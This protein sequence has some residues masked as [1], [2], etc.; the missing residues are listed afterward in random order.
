MTGDSAPRD[1]ATTKIR[2]CLFDMD[3]LLI[4]SEE[5]YTRVTNQILKEHGKG[6]LPWDVKIHLQGRPGPE[7]SR[8]F[9]D[10]AQLPYTPEEYYKLTSEKQ[11]HLWK[12]TKFMPGALEL[13]QYLDKHNVPFALATSSH[14]DNYVL[15]T[16]H[17][18]DGFDLFGKHI[19]V[20]DDER[21]P[22]GRG[23]PHPDIWQVALAS[24]NDDRPADD[25]IKPEECLVFEDGMPGVISGKAAGARV[26]WVPDQ[27]TLKVLGEEKVAELI[28]DHEILESLADLDKSK[29]GLP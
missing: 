22:K 21:I 28:G 24:L 17:L 9:L 29:Y 16:N 1:A 8:Y 19:V 10:W 13:L 26:V 2:A 12:E 18:R 6:E 11:R 4:N 15:K 23:K 5:I 25:Q 20:G 7:A 27:R 14:H 3:G